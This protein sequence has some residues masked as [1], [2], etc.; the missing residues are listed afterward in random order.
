MKKKK[1]TKMQTYCDYFIEFCFVLKVC[2]IDSFS[3]ACGT[4][5]ILR[6]RER[7][8]QLERKKTFDNATK[9]W[10]PISIRMKWIIHNNNE[11]AKNTIQK[12]TFCD[13]IYIKCENRKTNR[14]F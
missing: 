8:R 1:L 3:C 11:S 13:A 10:S 7:D 12:K 6:K 14:S 4:Y 9:Y 2:E 5:E